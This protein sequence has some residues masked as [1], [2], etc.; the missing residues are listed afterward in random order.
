MQFNE[1]LFSE[2]GVS[3]D[4]VTIVS[5]GLLLAFGRMLICIGTTSR[6]ADIDD[7]HDAQ[8][9]CT[10]AILSTLPH[11]TGRT[12]WSHPNAT[13]WLASHGLH[14]SQSSHGTGEFRCC[15]TAR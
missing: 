14:A 12:P 7:N 15:P 13:S 6:A 1:A 2:R 10:A 4:P 9:R 5:V 3:G 11:R 8:S